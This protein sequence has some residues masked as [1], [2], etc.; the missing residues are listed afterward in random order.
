MRWNCITDVHWLHWCV[1]WFEFESELLLKPEQFMEPSLEAMLQEF[2]P[3]SDKQIDWLPF[4]WERISNH[5]KSVK[6]D[7]ECESK[8][9]SLARIK[10]PQVRIEH[11]MSGRAGKVGERSARCLFATLSNR[12]F[13][14]FK[15]LVYL[16]FRRFSEIRSV[17][18]FYC[19]NPCS[20]YFFVLYFIQQNCNEVHGIFWHKF[21]N[22]IK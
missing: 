8:A 9:C 5:S 16:L 19:Q 18:R 7:V 13:K 21:Y 20:V 15:R 6:A 12:R 14:R 10:L 22:Q 3:F 1:N 4:G 17:C 11:E 2:R